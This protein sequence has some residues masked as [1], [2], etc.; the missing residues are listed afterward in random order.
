M[1]D[2]RSL[3]LTLDSTKPLRRFIHEFGEN[4]HLQFCSPFSW[5]HYLEHLRG[6]W[7]ILFFAE[8]HIVVN[9]VRFLHELKECF[10]GQVELLR[11]RLK[12]AYLVIGSREALAIAR[13]SGR[14]RS[15]LE[16]GQTTCG[17]M[18]VFTQEMRPVSPQ[19][20]FQRLDPQSVLF[21]R[22]TELLETPS[23]GNR[24][25][26]TRKQDLQRYR[27]RALPERRERARTKQDPSR[28]I[29]EE[30]RR[31]PSSFRT[32]AGMLTDLGFNVGLIN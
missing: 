21:A 3:K 10:N 5:K 20:H 11:T 6:I 15:T 25:R 18:S 17:T 8:L 14:K 27:Y 16:R 31:I 30:L 2:K 22:G 32:G 29:R 4:L 9:G 12:L 26:G 28:A 13:C 19:E 23:E 7:N 24:W 1:N